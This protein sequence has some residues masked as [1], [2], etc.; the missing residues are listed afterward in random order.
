MS[1]ERAGRLAA[2]RSRVNKQLAAAE[3]AEDEMEEIDEIIVRASK[4]TPS[5]SRIQR[6]K[7]RRDIAAE[8]SL[9]RTVAMWCII[10]GSILGLVTGAL[11]LSGNPSDILSSSLFDSPEH[12]SVSGHALEAESGEAVEGVRITLMSADGKTELFT[13]TTDSNGFYRFENVKI[14]L[15]VMVA[16][17]DGYITIERFF[18]PDLGGEDPLTMKPGEGVSEEGSADDILESNLEDV[19]ALTSAIAAMTLLFALV[20]FFAAAEAQR[21]VKYR[22]TQYLCGIALFSRGLIFFGPLLILFGMA[23]L[24]I[25]KEQFL[26]QNIE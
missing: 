1:D 19:V 9:T 26:D 15:M 3:D 7:Q 10:A 20:G 12:S 18:S 14:D 25:A 8:T 4:E 5:D 6:I 17:K 13:S 23:L 16:E 22:R 11:L 21:G 24:A 2:L